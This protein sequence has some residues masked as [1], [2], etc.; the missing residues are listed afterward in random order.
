MVLWILLEWLV[1]LLLFVKSLH[2]IHL[3]VL[4]WGCDHVFFELRRKLSLKL[5]YINSIIR[6]I[7]VIADPLIENV[8]LPCLWVLVLENLL[9]I[10]LNRNDFR[11]HPHVILIICLYYKALARCRVLKSRAR[12]IKAI[13]T[14]DRPVSAIVKD[15]HLIVQVVVQEIG[16]ELLSVSGHIILV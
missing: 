11:S 6:V 7:V 13:S 5:F 9:V 1:K 10:N 8:E 14:V 4:T 12:R 3:V 2:G 15:T 16:L